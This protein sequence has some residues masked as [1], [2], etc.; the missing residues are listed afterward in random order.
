MITLSCAA[1][2]RK[3]CV[4]SQEDLYYPHTFV[5]DLLWD[6]CHYISEPIIT[7]WPF[8]KIRERGIQRAVELM[9][10]SAEESRYITMGCVEKVS[11]YL[12]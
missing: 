3:Q 10:Y 6:A 4:T 5:Q 8:K 1:Q 2:F 11:T 9:R 7:R 12:D